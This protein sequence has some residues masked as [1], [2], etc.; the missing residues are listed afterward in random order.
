[1]YFPF[2]WP[3][4]F[5]SGDTGDVQL[6][7]VKFSDDRGLIVS[8]SKDTLHLWTAQ[9]RAIVARTKMSDRLLK[10][11]GTIVDVHW[12][13]DSTAL[14]LQTEKGHF[15][16]YD[17]I[18]EAGAMGER[19]LQFDYGSTYNILSDDNVVRDGVASYSLRQGKTF[20]SDLVLSCIW[21]R[22]NSIVMATMSGE[23][24]SINWTAEPDSL[25]RLKLCDV[26]LSD[27]IPIQAGVY[28]VDISHTEFLDA[29]VVVLSDF[30]VVCY[31]MKM[32]QKTN[33]AADVVLV[34]EGTHLHRIGAT[35]AAFNPKF[36]TVA[37]ACQ[38]DVKVFRVLGMSMGM[39]LSHVCSLR[40]ENRPWDKAGAPCVLSW[41]PDWN[42]LAL[43][44]ANN[45][46]SVWSSFGSL[47]WCSVTDH[48]QSLTD[49][50]SHNAL[51]GV[52][53]MDWGPHGYR[54]SVIFNQVPGENGTSAASEIIDFGFHKLAF[55]STISQSNSDCA[56]LVGEDR[57]HF[58]IEG[59]NGSWEKGSLDKLCEL[60]WRVV[61]VDMTYIGENWPIQF[62][63]INQDK[64]LLAVAGKRG[65]AVYDLTKGKWN[66]FQN[67]RVEKSFT[68]R[69]GISWF[70][71]LAIV[72]VNM[73]NRIE[74]RL[75]DCQMALND[76]SIVA[77][78]ESFRPVVLLN[79]FEDHIITLTTDRYLNLYRITKSDR[80]YNIEPTLAVS[81]A[82]WLPYTLGASYIALSL[83]GL[84]NEE[85]D[86][87]DQNTTP[88]VMRMQRVRSILVIVHGVLHIIPFN[89]TIDDELMDVDAPVILSDGVENLWLPSRYEFLPSGLPASLYM[90][91]K[92]GQMKV[93]LMAEDSK[94]G[95]SKRLMLK[96]KTDC[97]PAVILQNKSIILGVEADTSFE[98]KSYRNEFEFSTFEHKT[99]MYL[100]HILLHLLESRL[101]G[102]AYKIAQQ[103]YVMPY[104]SH[105]ME[106]MLHNV[107]EDEHSN[108][109]TQS[110]NELLPS[111]IDFV[112]KFPEYLEV[113]AHC[114][115]KTEVALW[116]FLFSRVG[117]PKLLFEACL[118]EDRLHTASSYLVILQ[119][120]EPPAISCK[121][122]TRLLDAALESDKWELAKELLRFLSSIA[123]DS[124]FRTDSITLS[125]RRNTL[126]RAGTAGSENNDKTD[127]D[128]G[129]ERI[130]LG[131]FMYTNETLHIDKNTP[132]HVDTHACANTT[133]IPTEFDSTR[134]N[135]TVAKADYNEYTNESRRLGVGVV[136]ENIATNSMDVDMCN[137][138]RSVGTQ[139]DV[140][141]SPDKFY[142]NVLMSQYAR[143]LLR[144]YEVR[145]L[146]VFS[147]NLSF[148]LRRWLSKERNRDARVPDCPKA[149]HMIHEQFDWPL[150]GTRRRSSSTRLQENI[151]S[152]HATP[153]S[154][155]KCAPAHTHMPLSA[156]LIPTCSNIRTSPINISRSRSLS[157][158]PKEV[159]KG[160]RNELKNDVISSHKTLPIISE[161]NYT[162][163]T[164]ANTHIHTHDKPREIT[165]APTYPSTTTRMAATTTDKQSMRRA[166][167]MSTRLELA[168]GQAVYRM[169]DNTWRSASGRRECGLSGSRQRQLIRSYSL[170]PQQMEIEEVKEEGSKN[171]LKYLLDLCLLSRCHEWAALAALA[172][173]DRMGLHAV[174]LSCAS[175][176]HYH[177]GTVALVEKLKE[178]TSIGIGVNYSTFLQ[179]VVVQYS[180]ALTRDRSATHMDLL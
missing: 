30:S 179:T 89:P 152:L 31:T 48:G 16:I 151:A 29:Y 92:E 45:G 139:T 24:M 126:R 166:T 90:Y 76:S 13:P 140:V 167:S 86:F 91:T 15:T 14:V 97:Y 123:N 133:T 168:A 75:Y 153:L 6:Q 87:R 164:N 4:I 101:D 18:S 115:R 21:T 44:H 38:R 68:V 83:L 77:K 26:E 122:A 137:S 157:T 107:L 70:G 84:D 132:R 162:Q 116:N 117:N 7:C 63:C 41:T 121:Y 60:R 172:L 9:P 131:G 142:A 129:Q 42:A 72:P 56:V 55:C 108:D 74:I 159:T 130:D 103:C 36:M 110:E 62:A 170:A 52:K 176:A 165:N 22:Q 141:R 43:G 51:L 35:R 25:T 69:G 148:P 163:D 106:L 8:A 98:S 27:S 128:I 177:G 156:D 138:V 17:V 20:E 112:M 143:K 37:V 93:W 33:T 125:S 79:S 32:K 113:I 39:T 19:V 102:I 61:Q 154:I 64:T 12:K 85:D 173:Q 40:Q 100:H 96:F 11:N 120:L 180:L 136:G 105:A 174:L 34:Y 66:F 49:T 175:D 145:A 81:L 99:Q 88:D 23:I 65:F 118:D 53:A 28:A 71:S 1:M 144:K 155:S 47:L 10:A 82:K 127:G 158:R 169:D 146:V 161:Q 78:V 178:V 147:R 134:T 150:P 111:V 119:T 171:A 149:F 109:L 94:K 73:N 95:Q 67:Q 80:G 2:G 54:L 57:V 114:A 124:Q 160:S 50:G 46:I 59:K 135:I 3:Q 104:F 5:T 58:H